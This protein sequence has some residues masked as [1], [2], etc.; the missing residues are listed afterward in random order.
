V[1]D[2][3]FGQAVAWDIPLTSGYELQAVPNTARDPGTHHFW[4]LR[5][6][7]LASDVRA[8]HPDAVHLTGYNYASHLVALI[9]LAREGIPVLFRGDSTLLDDEASLKEAAKRLALRSI[10]RY[11]AAFLCV[12]KNSADYY[13][14]YGVPGAKLFHCPHSIDF[15]RFAEP[16]GYLERQAAEWRRSL[17]IAD[18]QT[19]LLFAG[20]FEPKKRPIELM[21]AVLNSDATKLVLIMQGD[22]EL[23]GR[24]EALAASNPA[25]FRM[26]P[27]QNQST[28]PVVYRLGDLFVLPSLFAETW[29]LAVNEAMASGRPALVSDRVGCAADMIS[30]GINGDVFRAQDWS[31]FVRKTRSLLAAPER[32]R[33]LR[34]AARATARKFSIEETEAGLVEAL[35]FAV[36]STGGSDRRRTK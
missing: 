33:H 25:K 11:P 36:T 31:D 35:N 20:K 19:A 13:R 21:T 3:G 9:S 28:M 30:P 29:G 22:G 1:W 34:G 18:D 27:F 6:P 10:F 5:N 2:P 16:D 12:G 17:G 32:L 24:V 7:T 26:I 4:G 23:R 8:W 15:D 14:H